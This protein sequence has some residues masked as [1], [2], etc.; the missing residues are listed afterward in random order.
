MDKF[1]TDL[2]VKRLI[3]P[4]TVWALTRLLETKRAK[5]TLQHVDAR[6]YVTRK[7]AAKAIQRRVRNVRDNRVWLVAGAAAFALGIG[8]MVRAT[9]K[10]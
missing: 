9:R 10:G 4:V 5:K 7:N 1:K 3:T 8:M 6:A 2:V